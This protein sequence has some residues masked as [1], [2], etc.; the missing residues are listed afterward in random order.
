LA[1]AFLVP[2]LALQL[3]GHR[4]LGPVALGGCGLCMVVFLAALGYPLA[5]GA[6]S[7]LLSIHA[8]GMVY[9]VRPML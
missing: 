5:N 7:L 8:I 2:G 4:I 1:A 9:Y 3:R 6:I